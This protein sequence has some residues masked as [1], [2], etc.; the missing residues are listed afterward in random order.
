MGIYTP[1]KMQDYGK[2]MTYETL[3]LCF[4]SY[5]LIKQA[6]GNCILTLCLAFFCNSCPPFVPDFILLFPE[7]RG[8]P[9]R[10]SVCGCC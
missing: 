9:N 8:Y 6:F 1:F 7:E 10:K 3:V 5:V 2:K 4:I